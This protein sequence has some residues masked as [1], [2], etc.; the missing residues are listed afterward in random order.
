MGLNIEISFSVK[1]C[2]N[3]T[4]TKNFLVQLA[5]KYNSVDN[6]F[7]HEIEGESVTIK[8]NNY[9]HHISFDFDNKINIIN[10]LKELQ[11]DKLFIIE[12]IYIDN[13]I[14]NVIYKNKNYNTDLY[15]SPLIKD[16]SSNN[17]LKCNDKKNIINLVKNYIFELN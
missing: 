8:K 11:K 5:E 15:L 13:N 4:E 9:I 3:I 7:S 17:N 10:F 14:I 16:N 2:K 1:K 12:C 6:Y